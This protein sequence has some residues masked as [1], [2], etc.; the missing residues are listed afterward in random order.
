MN[1]DARIAAATVRTGSGSS[2]VAAT[3]EYRTV[4]VNAM[5]VGDD[6]GGREADRAR[7][8]D[9][10]E[11]AQLAPGWVGGRQRCSDRRTCAP[12][13]VSYCP[14][15][16]TPSHWAGFRATRRRADAGTEGITMTHTLALLL[17]DGD[18]DG[19]GSSGIIGLLAVILLLYWLFG[20]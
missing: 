5:Q 17:A 13:D 1:A 8:D 19:F 9:R 2:V 12:H 6:V 3:S 15:P 16:G 7:A 11:P 14:I 4:P 18:G 20:R 10:R